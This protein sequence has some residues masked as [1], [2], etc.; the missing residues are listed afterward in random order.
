MK[1][2]LVSIIMPAH[3]S[4]RYI[5][6]AIESVQQQIY[7]NWELIIVDDCSSDATHKII[8]RFI[9]ARIKLITLSENL[10]ISYARNKAIQKSTGKYIAFLDSDDVWRTDK[11]SK[12]INY[13]ENTGSAFTYT[14]YQVIN[15]YDEKVRIVSQMPSKVEYRDLL[16]SNFIGLLTAVIDS[17]LVKKEKI[18]NIPHEDYATWLSILRE[19]QTATLVPEVLANY[20]IQKRS[21]S[22]NKLKSMIWT[23]QIYRKNQHLGFFISIYYLLQYIYFGTR[24]HSN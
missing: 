8:S 11:L 15:E 22:S 20:R 14:Y 9:D 2:P 24:K 7:S 18:P 23:W 12:Q 21:R 3:N 17:E 16:K 1:E 4:E 19:N 13:M 6:T 10:G 5:K